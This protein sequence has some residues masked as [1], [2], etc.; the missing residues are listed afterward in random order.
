MV[1]QTVNCN[2]CAD[3]NSNSGIEL[4]GVDVDTADALLAPAADATCI[5]G[6][7]RGQHDSAAGS[8]T[9]QAA[10]SPSLLGPFPMPLPFPRVESKAEISRSRLS[11]SNCLNNRPPGRSHLLEKDMNRL[12]YLQKSVRIYLTHVP[13]HVF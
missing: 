7:V 5:C 4:A 8:N 9:T 12:F 6:C 10:I 1:A 13:G 11:K 2:N 3:V